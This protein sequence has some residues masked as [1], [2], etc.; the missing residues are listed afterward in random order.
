MTD[1][2]YLISRSCTT[3][4]LDWVHGEL[5]LLPHGLVRSSI[6]LDGTI[7]NGWRSG[8]GRTVPHPLP[9]RPV[10]AFDHAQILAAR[11]TN[12]VLP[13]D[14][15]A[16]ATL[17]RG[18]MGQGLELT[19]TDGRK[20]VLAWLPRDPAHAVLSETLPAVLRDRLSHR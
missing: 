5:W 3:G 20:H 15:I 6:G 16:A 18:R 17:S 19:M 14:R 9:Y 1:V 8:I 13:Y 12:K 11:R 10:A 7:A 4:W 2:A